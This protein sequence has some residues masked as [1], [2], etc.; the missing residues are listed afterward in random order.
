M[1]ELDTVPS[2][3]EHY[4][5]KHDHTA[6]HTSPFQETF[7]SPIA[8]RFR[9]LPLVLSVTAVAAYFNWHRLHRHRPLIAL[10]L[11]LILPGSVNITYYCIGYE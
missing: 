11:E 10:H 2:F 9:A 5:G 8:P 3:L 7:L 6:F 4:F 1:E